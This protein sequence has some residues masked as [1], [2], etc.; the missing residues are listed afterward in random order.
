MKI[1]RQLVFKDGIIMDPSKWVFTDQ[2]DDCNRHSY[3]LN[4]HYS[5]N[6]IHFSVSPLLNESGCF[7]RIKHATSLLN[8][9]CHENAHIVVVTC[10]FDFFFGRIVELLIIFLVTH[11]ICFWG[12]S[13]FVI[14]NLNELTS[15]PDSLTMPLCSFRN[16]SG[17]VL[18]SLGHQFIKVH[19]HCGYV[20]L[21]KFN[22]YGYEL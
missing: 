17:I 2:S 13:A 21:I 8:K 18:L 4:H 1:R 19:L 14:L 15:F 20:Y 6:T 16:L 3:V 10:N 11:E 7:V 22:Y 12:N 9:I 5:Q